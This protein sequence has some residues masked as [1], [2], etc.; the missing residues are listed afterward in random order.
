M[1]WGYESAL[2]IILAVI[3]F[4]VTVGAQ[5]NINFTYDKY[6]KVRNKK[7]YTGQ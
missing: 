2:T 4:L 7:G 6:R 5:I 1:I 3:A